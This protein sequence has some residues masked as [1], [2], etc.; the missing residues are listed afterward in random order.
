MTEAGYG[1][2]CPSPITPPTWGTEPFGAQ[3]FHMESRH[4]TGSSQLTTEVKQQISYCV[5]CC[6]YG[7][8]INCSVC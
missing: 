7:Q 1:A 5:D 6:F 8:L 3:M 4:V 2:A